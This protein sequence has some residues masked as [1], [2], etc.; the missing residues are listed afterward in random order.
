MLVDRGDTAPA[1]AFGEMANP[2]WPRHSPCSI[3]AVLHLT[4]DKEEKII[5]V[6]IVR[7]LK[8]NKHFY[9]LIYEPNKTIL[10]RHRIQLVKRKEHKRT[11]SNLTIDDIR[12]SLRDEIIEAYAEDNRND[13]EPDD[14][15]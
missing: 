13:Y 11:L 2:R 3:F 10:D 15:E 7:L 1:L 9:W 4:T 6:V 14:P 5:P 12:D 8:P